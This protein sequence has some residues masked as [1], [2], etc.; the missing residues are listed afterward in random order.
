MRYREGQEDQLGALGLAV[1]IINSLEHPLHQCRFGAA[2]Q[3]GL[4]R[5]A[6]KRGPTLATVFDHINLLRRY[7][8]SVPDS[9]ARGRLRR[10]VIRS[11]HDFYLFFRSTSSRN[12][13]GEGTEVRHGELLADCFLGPLM[14]QI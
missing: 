3:R 12:Q 9:V 8:F 14:Q 2:R 10:R 7:A 11:H 6:G 1:N 4:S 13:R 5:P